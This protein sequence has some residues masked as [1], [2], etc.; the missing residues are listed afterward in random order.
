MQ[1]GPGRASGINRASGSR[2]VDRGRADGCGWVSGSR[3]EQCTDRQVSRCLNASMP[4]G[5]AG[6]QV[7]KWTGGLADGRTTDRF[8]VPQ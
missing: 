4:R 3:M 2:G 6:G 1:D 8:S 7:K 5:Q